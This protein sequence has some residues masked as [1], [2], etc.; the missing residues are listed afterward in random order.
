MLRAVGSG[1]SWPEQQRA[2]G[3]EADRRL[4]GRGSPPAERHEP[5]GSVLESGRRRQARVT[6]LHFE[7]EPR[8]V[9]FYH[10]KIRLAFLLIA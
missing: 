10:E 2:D 4:I 1:K 3:R 8:L 9:V 7:Q 6:R 5:P